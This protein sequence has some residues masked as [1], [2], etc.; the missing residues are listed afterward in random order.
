MKKIVQNV[1]VARENDII[2][3]ASVLIREGKIERVV[4]EDAPNL[5]GVYEVIDGGGC[6]LV[7]GMIDVHIHGANGFDMMDG[8]EESIQEQCKAGRWKRS[9]SY[10]G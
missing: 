2:P 4:A 3:S 5:N 6:L 8:T 9:R 1:Q 10:S 7:P